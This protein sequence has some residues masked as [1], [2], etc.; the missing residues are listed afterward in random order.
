MEPDDQHQVAPVES[1]PIPDASALGR[2]IAAGLLDD[3]MWVVIDAVN[4]RMAVI[5][6]QRKQSALA[7]FALNDRVRFA[8][9]AKPQYLRGATGE[10]HEFYED[11]IV[12]CLD[13]ALGRFKS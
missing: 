12:V 2:A 4:R 10:I 1:W 11:K 7:A 5:D 3:D 13:R 8:D 9:N 6:E